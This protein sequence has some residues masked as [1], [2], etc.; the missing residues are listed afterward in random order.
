MKHV[1]FLVHCNSWWYRTYNLVKKFWDMFHAMVL[2]AP[3]TQ[4]WE[5]N[6]CCKRLCWLLTPT[7][8]G[9]RGRGWLAI[10]ELW[11]NVYILPHMP[12]CMCIWY[13]IRE[14]SQGI[15]LK[16]SKDVKNISVWSRCAFKTN[17]NHTVNC[18]ANFCWWSMPTWSKYDIDVEI[19]EEPLPVVSTLK[20]PFLPYIERGVW[21]LTSW[22][23]ALMCKKKKD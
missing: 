5:V 4:C 14:E 23:L 21:G 3:L 10:L 11:H 16:F 20:F 9:G 7:L 18:D 1:F 13:K 12:R 8:L 2:P 22:V 15:S 19:K 17:M 6:L